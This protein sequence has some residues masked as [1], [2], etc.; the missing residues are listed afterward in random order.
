MT[1]ALRCIV[2]TGFA[3]AVCAVQLRGQD[4]VPPDTLPRE[5]RGAVTYVTS[6]TA[7][8]DMGSKLGF[9]VG[10]TLRVHR[11]GAIAAV[12][13]VTHISSKSLAAAILTRT[14]AFA[15]GDEVFGTPRRAPPR[16]TPV[17]RG[18]SL[19]A[20]AGARTP[21]RTA[22]APPQPTDTGPRLEASSPG[23]AEPSMRIQGRLSLQYFA[24]ANHGSGRLDVNQPGIVASMSADQLF[25]LPLTL[26]LYSNHRYDA[27]PS[28]RRAA[29]VSALSNRVYQLSLRYGG[30]AD[31][32]SATVGRFIAPAVGGIGTIDGAMLVG[33]RGAWEA[34]VLLGS[35]PGYRDASISL[36]DPKTA[37]YVGY[38]SGD[39]ATMRVQSSA[40]LAQLYKSGAVDRTFLYVQNIASFGGTL[41]LYQ[42]ANIDLYDLEKGAAIVR[43]HL[44][45][46]FLSGTWRA[47]RW[48]SV[49]GS[50]ST[51]RG[52][53]YLRSF[54]M[55]ADSLFDR[56]HLQNSQLT[57]GVTLPWSMYAAVG[58]LLRT[59][60]GDARPAR[61]V[62]ARWTWSDVFATRTSLTCVGSLTDNVYNRTNNLSLELS[63][64]VID[65]LYVSLRA[66]HYEYRFAS[67]RL[68]TRQ[69]LALDAYWRLS[70]RVYAS[71]SYERT[72]ES[73]FTTD[74]IYLDTSIRWF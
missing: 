45:D 29:N 24:L 69:A 26:S 61:G 63:R 5:Q 60:E 7:Y 70:R 19:A 48:L 17:L 32:L 58:A 21:V 33:R 16:T 9:D 1:H 72:W 14:A 20:D 11:Q 22:T 12:L 54:G 10:D 27:R 44:S 40:A 30:V 57:F 64:D 4:A 71:L 23:G 65:D 3:L 74:R 42:N 62:H 39:H 51:R 43:P 36:A 59:R 37:A 38:A 68:L 15:A 66:Q 49:S 35:Q 13:L 52:I 67:S 6:T 2:A 50:W 56:S 18:D 31:P 73:G 55:I 34:G 25:D 47:M 8:V 53:W 28:D 41:S 46:V